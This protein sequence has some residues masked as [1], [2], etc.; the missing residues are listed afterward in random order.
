MRDVARRLG[1]FGEPVERLR[2]ASPDLQ[3]YERLAQDLV[4]A[5]ESGQPAA[6]QHLMAFFGGSITWDGLRKEVRKRLEGL[7]ADRPEGYFALPHA[8]LLLARSAGFATWAELVAAHQ[9]PG[10]SA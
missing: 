1:V 10:S 6:M 4:F 5:F 3:E 9:A 8:R 2:P 7:G